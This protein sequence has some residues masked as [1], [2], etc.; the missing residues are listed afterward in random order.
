MKRKS[1]KV[2]GPPT[3][4]YVCPF[5]ETYSGKMQFCGKVDLAQIT[6]DEISV[7]A[8]SP[9]LGERLQ[10]PKCKRVLGWHQLK[11]VKDK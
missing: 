10:C 7:L 4:Y 11:K 2:I 3:Y 6:Y 8:G 5:D 9:T 1:I